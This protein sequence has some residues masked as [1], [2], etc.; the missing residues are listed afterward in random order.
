[1]RSP[2]LPRHL[3][4]APLPHS[5]FHA[6][7]AYPQFPKLADDRVACGIKLVLDLLGLTSRAGLRKRS[8]TAPVS[9]ATKPIPTSITTTDRT[10]VEASVGS[11]S[12]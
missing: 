7:K 6:V 5:R 10:F 2:A 4:C 3:A 1:M 8:A 9:T 12:P 11:S